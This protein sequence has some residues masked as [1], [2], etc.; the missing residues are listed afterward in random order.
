MKLRIRYSIFLF[1]KNN[2]YRKGLN[3]LVVN[4]DVMWR[5]DRSQ[6]TEKYLQ[7]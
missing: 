5:E 3:I 2:L 6:L 4:E 7:P 1:A